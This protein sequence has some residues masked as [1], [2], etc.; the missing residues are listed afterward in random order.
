V[1]FTFEYTIQ[2][3]IKI[4]DK[5]PFRFTGKFKD[6]VFGWERENI[7]DKKSECD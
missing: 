5:K 4:N 7:S 3:F 1:T 6:G 2:T